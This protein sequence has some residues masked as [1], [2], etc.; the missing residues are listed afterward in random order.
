MYFLHQLQDIYYPL[1]MFNADFGYVYNYFP[2][3]F[4]RIADDRLA[5]HGGVDGFI[6]AR[7]PGRP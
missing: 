2:Q 5:R 7:F 1:E 3:G 4:G 6:R